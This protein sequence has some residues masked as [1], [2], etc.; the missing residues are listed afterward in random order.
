M[1]NR[2]ERSKR[3]YHAN[4]LD[5]RI[6]AACIEKCGVREAEKRNGSRRV[7]DPVVKS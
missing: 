1:G 4:N 7:W 5:E 2:L 6:H 3:I